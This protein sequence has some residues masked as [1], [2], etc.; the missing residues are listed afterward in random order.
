MIGLGKKIMKQY[1]EK[2]ILQNDKLMHIMK[3]L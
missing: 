3:T 2:K 1:A